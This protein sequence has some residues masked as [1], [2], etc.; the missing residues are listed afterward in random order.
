MSAKNS[1]Q[2]HCLKLVFN[3]AI[4]DPTLLLYKLVYRLFLTLGWQL[5]FRSLVLVSSN[6]FFVL[7]FE[8]F[9]GAEEIYMLSKYAKYE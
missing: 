3:N 9:A 7:Y 2:P 4:Y 8:A 6:S 1:T 5:T